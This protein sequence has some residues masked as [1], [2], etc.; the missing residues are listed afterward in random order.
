MLMCGQTRGFGDQRRQL[1]TRLRVSIVT[2]YERLEGV[3]QSGPDGLLVRART[4]SVAQKLRRL[5]DIRQDGVVLRGEVPEERA[6]GDLGGCADGLN[7]RRLVTVRR[8]SQ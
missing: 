8:T 1:S 7:C 5:V 3:A 4:Q 6:P 2:I